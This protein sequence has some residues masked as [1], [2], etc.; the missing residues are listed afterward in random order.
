MR[1]DKLLTCITEIKAVGSS[2]STELGVLYHSGNP[3]LFVEQTVLS[4][5]QRIRLQLGVAGRGEYPNND[6]DRSV[7]GKDGVRVGS[8]YL[9]SDEIV[10]TVRNGNRSPYVLSTDNRHI[11]KREVGVG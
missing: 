8:G 1:D 5:N 10:I 6:R 9:D 3:D 7:V 2:L 4:P 11:G